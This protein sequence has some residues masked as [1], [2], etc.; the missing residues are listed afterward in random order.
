MRVRAQHRS[1]YRHLPDLLRLLREEAGL[2][3]RQLGER[4]K[5]PQSWVYNCET[6]ARRVDITE[7]IAWSRACEVSPKV[8]FNRLLK[9]IGEKG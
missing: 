3:Q 6:G 8:A 7:F 2:S 9:K 5:R 4:L 1:M